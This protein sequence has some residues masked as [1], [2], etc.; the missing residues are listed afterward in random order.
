MRATALEAALVERLFTEIAFETS[1]LAVAVK[2]PLSTAAAGASPPT[3]RAAR[4]AL[5]SG[6]A[7]DVQIHYAYRGVEW[8]DTLAA[9]ALGLR[10][11][12]V[13]K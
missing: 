3:L 5:L 13:R 9:T 4:D 1:V 6:V 12:R 10:I 11:V 8:W 2:P 7:T